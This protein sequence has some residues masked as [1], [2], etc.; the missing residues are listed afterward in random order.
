M[1]VGLVNQVPFRAVNVEFPQPAGVQAQ[2]STGGEVED[3]KKVIRDN[4]F[5]QKSYRSNDNTITISSRVATDIPTYTIDSEGNVIRGISMGNPQPTLLISKNKEMAAYVDLC[6]QQ[7][8][9]INGVVSFGNGEDPKPTITGAEDTPPANLLNGVQNQDK[10][11]VKPSKAEEYKARLKDPEWEKKYVPEGNFI[12][13][14]RQNVI[15]GLEYEITP[16]GK[17][18]EVGCWTKPTV[19][20]EDDED[21]KKMFERNGLNNDKKPENEP[22]KK[23]TFREKVANVWKFFAEAGKMVEAAAKGVVYGALTGTALL[24]GAWLFRALPKAFAKEGPT[25]WNTIRHPLKNIGKT[26]KII[27][28][29]GSGLVLGYHLVAGKLQANQKTAVIDHKMKTGHRDA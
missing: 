8:Q 9:L 12:H 17:V 10:V 19:I 21:S 22:K 20:L 13:M 5:W 14:K 2:S 6:K 1:K 27:A 24:G 29:V 3:V 7:N 16:D 23:T 15:D 4:N 11:E 28:G 18:T 25:L 26:G